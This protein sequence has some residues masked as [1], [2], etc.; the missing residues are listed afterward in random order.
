MGFPLLVYAN[1][2]NHTG[3]PQKLK[4]FFTSQSSLLLKGGGC[5][6]VKPPHHTS[7]LPRMLSRY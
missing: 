2:V 1:P 4:F 3:M 7:L 6:V 5:D